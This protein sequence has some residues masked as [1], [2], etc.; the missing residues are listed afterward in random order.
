MLCDMLS[1]YRVAQ[2]VRPL[3]FIAHLLRI[4]KSLKQKM[5]ER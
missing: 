5:T 2:K 4:S 3:Y 1:E